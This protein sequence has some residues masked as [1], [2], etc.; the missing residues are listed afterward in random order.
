M[1]NSSDQIKKFKYDCSIHKNKITDEFLLTMPTLEILDLQCDKCDNYC[2][3]FPITDWSISRLVHLVE[4]DCS[5]C[6]EISDLSI[7]L[8]IN[9]KKLTHYNCPLISENTNYKNIKKLFLNDIMEIILSYTG[10][11]KIINALYVHY[12]N[13]LK[14]NNYSLL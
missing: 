10:D 14:H 4:L 5:N 7:N 11:C 12:P 1:A 9:L 8:L 13:L 2:A 3:K 6:Q